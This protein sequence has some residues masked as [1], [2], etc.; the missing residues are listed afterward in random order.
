MRLFS[1]STVVPRLLTVA[2]LS[3]GACDVA[4]QEM[5]NHVFHWSQLELDAVRFDGASAGR[6]HGAGWVGTDFDRLWWSTDG[7][8]TRNGVGSAEVTALYGRYVRRFW[9]F[10]VGY[11]Q[12]IEPTAQGY[13]AVGFSGLAPYWFEVEALAFVSQGGDPSLRLEAE[14]DLLLT[15]RLIMSVLAEADWLVTADD[16]RGLGSGVADFEAGIRARYEVGRKFA[17]YV[18]LLWIRERGPVPVGMPSITESGL[19]L[20]AGL[21]LIY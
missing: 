17:P 10:V 14:S 11:R 4:A 7:G 2:I 13:L 12:D 8:V 5:D 3:I 6:W 1:S 19:Q 18:D 16:R 15:Q 21:R 20:G 9:D